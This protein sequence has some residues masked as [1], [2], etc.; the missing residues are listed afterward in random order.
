MDWKRKKEIGKHDLSSGYMEWVSRDN[1]R[2]LKQRGRERSTR[3]LQNNTLNYRIQWL[4]VGIQPPG[5]FSLFVFRN[6]TWKA[7]FWSFAE[8]KKLEYESFQ[9]SCTFKNKASTFSYPHT[10]RQ[11]KKETHVL[12]KQEKGKRKVKNLAAVSVDVPVLAA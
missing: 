12:Y 5:H 6:S 3:T 4:N 2:E 9:S 11:N 7:R 8:N 1:N 10:F